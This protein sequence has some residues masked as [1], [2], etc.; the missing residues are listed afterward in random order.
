[1]HLLF[2]GVLSKASIDRTQ[3]LQYLCITTVYCKASMIHMLITLITFVA[4]SS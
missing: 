3:S 4:A 2:M 1:M